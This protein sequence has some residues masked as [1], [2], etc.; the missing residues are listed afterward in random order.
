[1]GNV[2]LGIRKGEWLLAAGFSMLI[3]GHW[4]FKVSGFSPAAGLKNGQFN[5]KRNEGIK[6]PKSQAPNFKQITMTEIQ[7]SKQ[8][9]FD[10]I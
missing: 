4:R 6:N 9:A 1:M 8:L 3:T 7:S 2:E 5:R 10:L